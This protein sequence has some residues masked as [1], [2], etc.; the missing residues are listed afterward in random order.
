MVAYRIAGA[1]K[2]PVG[3]VLAGGA[4]YGSVQ[5]GM[6]RALADSDLR[7]D[8]V[9][10]TSVG[11]LNGAALAEN[12]EEAP[13]RLTHLWANVTREH[14]FGGVLKSAVALAAGKSTVVIT[15]V[16]ESV[17]RSAAWK[18]LSSGKAYNRVSKSEQMDAMT[19][20]RHISI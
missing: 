14:I 1:V 5:V 12:P 8:L 7:P 4:S 17:T 2:R 11:S 3:Y 20:N 16:F 6:L 10:G 9:V 13:E 19:S 15:S 18:Y